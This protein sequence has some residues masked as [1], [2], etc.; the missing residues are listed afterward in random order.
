MKNETHSHTYENCII[1]PLN[2]IAFAEFVRVVS[3][4]SVSFHGFPGDVENRFSS[5]LSL[6]APSLSLSYFLNRSI[7]NLNPSLLSSMENPG[8]ALNLR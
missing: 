6:S 5:S 3:G 8:G 4:K 7:K 1:K 2:V